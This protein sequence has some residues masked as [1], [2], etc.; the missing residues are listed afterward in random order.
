MEM[1]KPAMPPLGA[2]SPMGNPGGP[3][4]AG[5]KPPMADIS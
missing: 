1:K 5:W 4:P 3:P 2:M